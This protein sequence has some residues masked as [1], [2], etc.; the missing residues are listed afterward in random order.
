MNH[1][2]KLE[3]P[4]R[5]IDLEKVLYFES[6]IVI[7]AEDTPLKERQI[8]TEEEYKEAQSKY[9][10]GFK[11]SI[12]AEAID[13]ILELEPKDWI[14]LAAERIAKGEEVEE[15]AEKKKQTRRV[16]GTQPAHE[17]EDYSGDYN[18]PG[19]GDIKVFQKNGSLFFT[20][21]EIDPVY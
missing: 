2:K 12:G 21:N 1:W 6:Y 14:S 13:L 15:E 3:K 5:K 11:A 20:Y 8:L 9:G 18:H 19:Y 4:P 16:T 7:D 10:D 17:L